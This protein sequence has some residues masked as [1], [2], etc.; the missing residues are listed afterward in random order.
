VFLLFNTVLEALM[1]ASHK[2]DRAGG[3]PEKDRPLTTTTGTTT[4]PTEGAAAQA[5][6]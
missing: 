5:A 2:R 6:V 3:D 1:W 4:G